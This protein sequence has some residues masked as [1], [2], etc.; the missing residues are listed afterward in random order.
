LSTPTDILIQVPSS[1]EGETIIVAVTVV[2]G[3]FY[4]DGQ[5][6]TD[7]KLIEGNTYIF[8]QSSVND[9]GHVLGIS[10]SE[11]GAL[12]SDLIYSYNG[13]TTTA[14]T[15]EIYL[16]TYGAFFES[17]QFEISYTVPEGGLDTLYFFSTSSDVTG[18]TYSVQTP[19]QNADSFSIYENET[20]VIIGTLQTEDT[21]ENDT[22]SYVLSGDNSDLFEIVDGQLK[23]KDGVSINY[24]LNSVLNITLTST[25]SSGASFSK[26]FSINVIGEHDSPTA[27]I[28]S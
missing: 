6:Q 9:G 21:D 4:F 7:F 19:I 2:N 13:N 23:V 15:Y 10:E 8:Q 16:A 12:V 20:G 14:S 28:L 5:A 27:V 25:D 3:Q 1:G 17:Y 11:G 22:H 24:E 18:G 26:D